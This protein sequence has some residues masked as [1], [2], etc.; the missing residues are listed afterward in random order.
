MQDFTVYT[1]LES[2]ALLTVSFHINPVTNYTVNWYKEDLA[3][4]HIRISDSVDEEHIETTCFIR[5]VTHKH[6][7]NYTVQVINWAISSDQNE[8]TFN[9]TLKLEGRKSKI[10][11]FYPV[12]VVNSYL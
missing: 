4:Q 10:V 2:A 7:G 6:L 12:P 3:P 1:T 5:K 9:I 8:I 11:S